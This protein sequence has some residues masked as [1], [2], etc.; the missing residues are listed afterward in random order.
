MSYYIPISAKGWTR[1]E[2]AILQRILIEGQ[3]RKSKPVIRPDDHYDG[4]A[5]YVWRNVLFQISER[6]KDQCMPVMCFYELPGD[7][8]TKSML[9]KELD[10]MVDRVISFVPKEEWHGIRRWA[11]LV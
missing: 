7:M 4:L 8:E 2:V 9:A 1:I 6:A 10:K 5:A 3:I 11:W